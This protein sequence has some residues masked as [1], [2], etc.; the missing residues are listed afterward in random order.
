MTVDRI[1][2][3][4]T[5]FRCGTLRFPCVGDYRAPSPTFNNVPTMST[6]SHRMAGV[7]PVAAFWLEYAEGE[8]TT[9][10]WHDLMGS[11]TEGRD[12]DKDSRPGSQPHLSAQDPRYRDPRG[13]IKDKNENPFQHVD[14]KAEAATAVQEKSELDTTTHV[15]AFLPGRKRTSRAVVMRRIGSVLRVREC[16]ERVE[17]LETAKSYSY[18]STRMTAVQ[19]TGVLAAG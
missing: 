8:L 4:N 13:A 3:K 14:A 6:P 9:F 15:V 1:A 11:A 18:D 5:A 7:P 19:G 2:K 12:P 17:G 16:G 10:K